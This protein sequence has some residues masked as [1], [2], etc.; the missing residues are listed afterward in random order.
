M[1]K[2]AA[3]TSVPVGRT[4]CEIDELLRDWKA[5]GIQ[6]TDDWEQHRIVLRFHWPYRSKRFIARF[7]LVL[8]QPKKAGWNGPTQKQLDTKAAQETR[9]AFRTLLLWLK[10]ALNAV[11]SGIV[12]A[13]TVFLPWL[14]DANGTTI[15]EHVLPKL[16]DMLTVS[17]ARLLPQTAGGSNER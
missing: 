4:R 1:R 8:P 10:A 9:T 7:L 6:W 3:H 14:E 16:E 17:C 5:T 15:A 13:E 2:F 11:E 12:D